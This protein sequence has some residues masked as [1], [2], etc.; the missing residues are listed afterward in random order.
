VAALAAVPASA[1][2]A[3]AKPKP[4]RLTV[5]SVS[6]PPARLKVGDRFTVTGKVRN[7]GGRSTPASIAFELRSRSGATVRFA[8]GADTIG[9]VRPGTTRTFKARARIAPTASLRSTT[10][11]MLSACAKRTRGDRT[12]ACRQSK[13]GVTVAANAV[14]APAP[15]AAAPAAPATPGT[16]AAPTTPTTPSTPTT[17]TTPADPTVFTPGA[18][19]AGDSL[20]PTIGNGGYDATHYDLDLRYT[21]SS[22]L[23]RGTTT[24]TAQATQ[25]LSEYSFDLTAWNGVT[26]VTVDGRPAKYAVDYDSQKLVVTPPAGIKAGT[27]FET[28]VT[29]GGIQQAYIDPDGSSEGFVPS[30]TYGA[31]VVSEPVGAMG[32]FP[33]NNVPFDK[34][35]FTTRMTV[36]YG[37]NVVASGVLKDKTDTG[38]A[39]SD[40]STYVWDD[41]DPTST[42][43]YQL[44]IGKYDLSSP[45]PAAPTK[46]APTSG[47]L[48]PSIL[49]PSVPYYTAIDS[50][51]TNKTSILGRLNGTAAGTAFGQNGTV[52]ALDYF[53]D[54]YGVRYPF[55]A[56]GGIVPRQSV[57]YSLETQG[58]PT[59]ATSTSATNAGPSVSTVAHENGHMYF[60]DGVT[61]T[62]WKDIWLNEGMTEFSTWLYSA[63]VTVPPVTLDSRYAQYYTANT[64]ASFWTVPPANPPTAADIFDTNAMYN[65]GA[66]TMLQVRAVLGEPTFRAMMKTWLTDHLYGNVTTE[67]F[68]AL[69]KAT[70]PA[71]ADRWT[72]FFRQWLYTSYT[73]AG[74]KPTMNKDNFDTFVLP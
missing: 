52:G 15:P 26:G 19:S 58:K 30:T 10:T 64:S 57:G 48:S 28:A 68:I 42:Y 6:A 37:W 63:N 13:R 39:A 43:L 36:P 31:I 54:Y 23:L 55:S 65:R 50:T 56:M 38:T 69:V 44:A 73:G 61:L 41:T 27:T 14:D 67:Q 66:T 22:K 18:R 51:F 4:A 71:R 20:F 33:N 40:L 17:P 74:N 32:F 35:T 3:K 9:K 24:V 60:G 47:P 49:N 34:A 46:T 12:V 59:Y 11:F 21:I 29:Y 8:V 72:E 2:A 53:A 25:N 45:D 70:D 16:P 1:S 62:Q 7:S 5:T